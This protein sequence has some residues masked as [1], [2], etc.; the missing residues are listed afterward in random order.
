M[1]TLSLAVR[2]TQAEDAL[3]QLMV[4]KSAVV[5]VDQNNE[6]VEYTAANVRSLRAYIADL[7]REIGTTTPSPMKVW[8]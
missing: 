2:L 4:G 7:K 6:R 3:H 1:A 5:F 8:V